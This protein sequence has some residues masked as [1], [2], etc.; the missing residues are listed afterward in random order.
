MVQTF[1]YGYSGRRVT[2]QELQGFWT[3]SALHPESRRRHLKMYKVA[4]AEGVDVGCGGAARSTV[5]QK[6]LFM[7]RYYPCSGGS[8]YWD[9]RRWCKRSGVASA[10]PPGRS[11]HEDDA[12]EGYA[13]AVDNIGNLTWMGQNAHRFGLKDFSD[14]N[15]EP[16]HTQFV[17]LPNGRSSYN[18]ALHKFKTW[19]FGDDTPDPGPPPTTGYRWPG[20]PI[21]T[22]ALGSTGVQAGKLI[23]VLKFWLWYPT[24]YMADGND[25][26]I[27]VRSVQGIKTMQFA[28]AQTPDGSYG[29]KTAK[30]YDDFYT[31]HMDAMNKP[32]PAPPGWEWPTPPS[33]GWRLGDLD[34]GV[35]A[36][37]QCLNRIVPPLV[38]GIQLC[39]PN[40]PHYS[41]VT[42]HVVYW[43][44][45]KLA[46]L[47][48]YSDRALDGIY[49][50]IT[51]K[52]AAQLTLDL[53][54]L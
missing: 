51:H 39:D 14:V 16:W 46:E 1:A 15:S 10:A 6:T 23:D 52:A 18:P 22:L 47:D 50:P 43:L 40:D 13:M 34:I 35:A 3:W 42:M 24:E 20:T 54:N 36:L 45:R 44:Q 26:K 28:L 30:A 29:P 5:Q 9:G 17:E 49:G 27:G 21:P 53:S 41:Q 33:Q 12:L 19:D 31:R 8:I 48:R 7:N 25:S 11:W 38:P 2:E 4:Q 32:A 37:H